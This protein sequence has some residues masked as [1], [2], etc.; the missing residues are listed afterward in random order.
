MGPKPRPLA[1]RFWEKVDKTGGPDACWPWT[2]AR[3]KDGYGMF[4]WSRCVMKYAH[5]VAWILTNGPTEAP[6]TR[7]TCDNPPCCNPA[8]ILEGDAGS[9]HADMIER[10]RSPRGSKNPQAKI[11]EAAAAEIRRR[12][13]EGERQRTLAAEYRLSES[14]VSN[15]KHGKLWREVA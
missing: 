12:I 10:G 9:N 2:A 14:T 6:H 7:H 11:T 5:R 8:H 4:G 15:I 13:G 1:D 3:N